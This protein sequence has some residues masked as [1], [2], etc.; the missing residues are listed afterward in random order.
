MSQTEGERQFNT[1][2]EIKETFM[3]DQSISSLEQLGP[4]E[5]DLGD[6]L[7]AQLIEDFRSRLMTPTRK[8]QAKLKGQAR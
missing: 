7:A 2:R 3:Y 1:V 6:R 8:A 5:N 4:K